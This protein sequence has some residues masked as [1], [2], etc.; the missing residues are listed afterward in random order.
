MNPRRLLLPLTPLYAAA[1]AV[2]N[3]LYSAGLLRPKK[4]VWPVISVG[5]LSTGGAGKTPFVLALHALLAEMGWQADVLSRGYG[6]SESTVAQVEPAGSA[7]RF[8]DEPLLLARAGLP[9][10][11]GADRFAAGLLAEQNSSTAHRVHILDDGMQHRKLARQMEIVLLLPSDFEDALLPGG[12]LREPLS[13]LRRADV[14]VLRQ[15]DAAL[16]LRVRELL[17]PRYTPHLWR[18]TRALRFTAP[19]GSPAAAPQRPLA[20]CGLARPQSFAHSLLHA[21]CEPLA[22]INFRDHHRYQLRDIHSLRERAMALGAAG[23]VTTA[24]DACKLDAVMLQTLTA[25]APLCIAE[26]ET[27]I[28]DAPAAAAQL[29]ALLRRNSPSA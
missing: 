14:I 28:V 5:N 1:L 15:E 27:G 20:F 10:F 2:K 6:R 17:G 13:A 12:N 22:Q 16:E 23:F 9:V 29:A 21:G 11:V 19:D 3:A 18:I 26:L 24:K 4:L 8:G 7:V 25:Y